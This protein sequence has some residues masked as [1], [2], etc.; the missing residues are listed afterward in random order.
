MRIL[1]ADDQ[2]RTR[3]SLRSLLSTLPF[4]TEISEA[5]DTQGVIQMVTTSQPDMVLMDARMPEVDGVEATRV[6]K[7]QWPAVKVIVLSMYPEYQQPA[8]QAGADAFVSKGEPP[9][10][11]LDAIYALLGFSS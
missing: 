4:S 9:N 2:K 6:I 3:K 7:S 10:V 1:I 5:E 11:L 8:L